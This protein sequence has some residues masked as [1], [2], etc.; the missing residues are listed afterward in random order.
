MPNMQQI[1]N[2]IN[3]NNNINSNI[4]NT[5]NGGYQFGGF[6]FNLPNTNNGGY[7]FGGFDFN[8]AQVQQK[9]LQNLIPKNNILNNQNPNF[10][11]QQSFPPQFPNKGFGKFPT[12]IGMQQGMKIKGK[13]ILILKFLICGIL[14]LLFLKIFQKDFFYIKIQGNK[15]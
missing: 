8:V 6:D 1:N 5:N 3:N 10:Q 7:Q 4:P 14:L 2:N 12:G 15:F 11:N 9:N 13:G